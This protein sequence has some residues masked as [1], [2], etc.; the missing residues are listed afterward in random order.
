MRAIEKRL[1]NLERRWSE[2]QL[3]TLSAEQ[4][5]E[6]QFLEDNL[7][8]FVRGAWPSID[9]SAFVDNWAIDG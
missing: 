5:E 3:A 2:D 6:I 7:I 1:I 9:N 8:E 4:I